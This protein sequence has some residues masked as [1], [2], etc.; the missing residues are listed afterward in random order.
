MTENTGTKTPGVDNALWDT[1]EK[2]ATAID[3]IRQ[4]RGYRPR[5][6]KRLSIPKQN[7]P[8]RPLA[9]PT[10]RIGRG[11]PS[12]SQHSKRLPKPLRIPMPMGS[13]RNAAAHGDSN[14]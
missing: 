7:G 10:R 1:P 11:K 14:A 2:K 6:L 9:I 5:P 3:R 8:Q 4:W 12:I 13:V